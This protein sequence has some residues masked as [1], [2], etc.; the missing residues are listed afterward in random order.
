[1]ETKCRKRSCSKAFGHPAK[2]DKNRSLACNNSE[3]VENSEFDGNELISINL[4]RDIEQ[5]QLKLADLNASLIVVNDQI[6]HQ[7]DE[8]NAKQENLNDLSQTINQRRVDFVLL[9]EACIAKQ[10]KL[11]DLNRII[12]ERLIEMDKLNMS[13]DELE[14]SISEKKDM[15]TD[16]NEDFEQ[17]QVQFEDLVATVDDQTNKLNKKY[18]KLSNKLIQFYTKFSDT[19]KIPTSEEMIANRHQKTTRYKRRAETDNIL[20]FIHGTPE[21]AM[22][23]AWDFLTSKADVTRI[24]E[25]LSSFKRGNLLKD[26]VQNITTKHRENNENLINNAL[27]MRYLVTKSRRTYQLYCRLETS[28][29][30]E[31]T[32]EWTL[33]PGLAGNQI[34]APVS[35]YKLDK[36]VKSMDMGEVHPIEGAC[37]AFRTVSSL[38]HMI[39]RLTNR[40]YVLKNCLIWF[41][42][43]ENHFILEF[44]DDGAPEKKGGQ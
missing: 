13:V 44:S 25:L 38:C 39:I 22:I 12:N 35:D 27:A 36:H 40:L 33:N 43:N 37:G 21:G 28:V 23:G 3:R 20:K 17:R 7:K 15:I 29:Y 19:G 2:C 31:E 42:G 30:N 10:D 11:D 32:H 6:T 24:Q 8:I 14:N 5:S 26:L 16:L 41:K 9:N 34:K 18:E 4:K 1:M